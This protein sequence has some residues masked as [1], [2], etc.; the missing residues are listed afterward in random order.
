[1]IR[2]ICG[3][4]DLTRLAGALTTTNVDPGGYESST[5]ELP[6][7][8]PQVNEGDRL[9]IMDG[10]SC[11]FYGRV[12]EVGL[13]FDQGSN[14][15][16][17]RVTALGKGAVLKDV[18]HQQ[19]YVDRDL[20]QWGPASNRRRQ[21]L[22]AANFQ[23]QG[24][25]EVI[26]DQTNGLP[27]ITQHF[28][29]VV[30]TLTTGPFAHVE[31]WYD[32]LGNTIAYMYYDH[33]FS[34]SNVNWSVLASLSTDDVTTNGLDSTASLGGTSTAGYITATATRKFALL[35]AFYQL[36]TSSD[37]EFREYWRNLA[38]YGDHGLT[39]RGSDPGGFYPSDIVAFAL[40]RD[41][42]GA[43]DLRIQ[44]TP[45]YIVR[46]LNA[47]RKAVELEQVPDDMA[48]LVGYHWGVWEP[49]SPFGDTPI[50]RFQA[51][52]ANPTAT[53]YIENA[54]AADLARRLSDY[55][56][57]ARVSYRDG[58][59]TESVAVVTRP[60]SRMPDGLTRFTSYDIGVGSAAA[61]S[62]F[63]LFALALEEQQARGAGSVTLPH[64]VITD[65]GPMGAH[66]LKAGVDRL[67]IA[68]LP[69]S[70]P[71]VAADN[72]R[73]DTF[74][75]SRISTQWSDTGTPTTT[76]ELDAGSNLIEV[77]QARLQAAS[78]L[79]GVG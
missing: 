32:A 70:G 10:L 69:N 20:S 5:F 54:D 61:A 49:N 37:G 48:K 33:T 41:Y 9:L 74:R 26:P 42:P 63:G 12:D 1:M 55:H 65:S 22:L 46:H 66:L 15:P 25:W 45:G 73:F 62:A 76:A 40:N 6:V 71:V 44:D 19:L 39:R 17:Q 77:I 51:P 23:E 47:Y 11:V 16:R 72:R 64:T 52:P 50:F 43:I 59:G 60:N 79:V 3:A 75:I 2:I 67:R 35:S 8:A 78:Q 13:L 14:D 38:V 18:P 36:T 29:R 4:N 21:Q 28:S 30:S 57:V 31:T 27:A 56:N 34:G 53:C 24:E 58:A 68:N 7:G